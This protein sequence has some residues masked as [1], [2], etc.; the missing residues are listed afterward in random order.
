MWNMG[1]TP[2]KTA[3][4][5]NRKGLD[6]AATSVGAAD[7]FVFRRVTDDRFVHV[8]GLGRGE[9]WAGN[10]DLIPAEDNRAQEA[11]DSG[12][13]VYVSAN[14]PV[15]VF[16]PYY[17]QKAVFVPVPPD[18]LVVF[19]GNGFGKSKA[20]QA[21]LQAAA[22]HAAAAVAQ[23][24]PAKRLADELELLH[25]MQG[26][27]QTSAVH[28][29]EMMRH[30][31]SSAVAALS[32]DLGVFYLADLDMIEI[33]EHEESGVDAAA[34][35]PAMRQLFGRAASLPACIQDSAVEPLPAPLDKGVTSHYVLPVG[36]PALGV[37][38]LLHTTARP[39][40]F[41]ILCREI[42]VRLA[43]GAEPLLRS[44]LK[45]HELE[46]QLDLVG[47][48]ARIDPLTK[49]PNRRAWEEV[50]E[51]LGGGPA[52]IIVLDVDQLKTVNDERGH[53]VGDEYLQAV[54][55]AMAAAVRQ[56]DF[57]ARVGGD[58]FAV[59]L[60]GADETAC[61]KVA[62]RLNRAL[63]DHDAFAGYALAASVGY[64]ATP[65]APSLHDAW[66]IADQAMYRVKPGANAGRRSAAA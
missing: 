58:E 56:D 5:R 53:H 41:T 14:R 28:I 18:V 7:V 49:L 33:A 26:L 44:A 22:K 60:P 15:R 9:S 47:R 66:R 54:A 31:A 55:A 50:L 62:R 43:D 30:V 46:Q 65:P 40:G 21:T 12:R 29:D 48:D 36:E 19:G 42:G 32:C 23:I 64:A 35:L 59:L 24:S 37:L 3:P 20:D 16:G 2:D 27:A 39:R 25:A 8:G 34:L 61:R 51:S 10:V 52:A 6:E 4:A 45:L 11:I 17:E 38:A 13:V 1:T 57:I 63:L